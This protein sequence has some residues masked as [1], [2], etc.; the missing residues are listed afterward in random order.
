[1]SGELISTVKQMR[2]RSTCRALGVRRQGK[3]R[4]GSRRHLTTEIPECGGLA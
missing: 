3:Y 2:E 4:T 1:M